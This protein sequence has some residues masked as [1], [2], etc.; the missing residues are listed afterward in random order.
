MSLFSFFRAPKKPSAVEAKER[1]QIVLAHERL[2][3]ARPDY[4]QRM[5]KDI[6]QVIAKYVPINED[7]ISVQFE[8]TGSVS[9]LEVNIEL[10]NAGLGLARQTAS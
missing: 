7:K 1:L 6:L 10:P 3:Q 5:H 4:L 8:N 2:D 9:L